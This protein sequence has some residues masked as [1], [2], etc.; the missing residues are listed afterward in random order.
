MTARSVLL[1]A[2]IALTIAA[3]ASAQT[4]PSG[5]VLSDGCGRT[6]A[7]CDAAPA[8][9]LRGCTAPAPTASTPAPPAWAPAWG[10]HRRF[11]FRVPLRGPGSIR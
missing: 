2:A 8:C 5:G 11:A 1:S 9:N 3:P 10:W 6:A 7:Q 4:R